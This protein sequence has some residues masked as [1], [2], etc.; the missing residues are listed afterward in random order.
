MLVQSKLERLFLS[1]FLNTHY[2][3]KHLNK[4]VLI[5]ISIFKFCQGQTL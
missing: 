3:D 2:K 5:R 1:N 4:P